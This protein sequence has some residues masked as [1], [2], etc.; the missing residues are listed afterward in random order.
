MRSGL[1][2][3]ELGVRT[4]AASLLG[5]WVDVISKNDPGEDK[6]AESGVVAL[7]KMFDLVESNVAADVL[8]SVFVTRADIFENISFKGASHD[9]YYWRCLTFGRC[10]L[11]GLDT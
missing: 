3:R 7:L 10:L 2:D 1:G 9:H 4:A 11:D 5:T 6:R 8:L